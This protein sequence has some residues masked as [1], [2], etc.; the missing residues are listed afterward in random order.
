MQQNHILYATMHMQ[1]IICR[2][3]SAR[4]VVASWSIESMTK[5]H[6]M[7]I[8]SLKDHYKKIALKFTHILVIESS[9]CLWIWLVILNTHC[10]YIVHA[11]GI[12]FQT[13]KSLWHVSKQI[14]C[15]FFRI[16]G[17]AVTFFEITFILN[18]CVCCKYVSILFIFK[19]K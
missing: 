6:W 8:S 2:Q 18:K 13:M 1:T 15:P 16:C 11:Q 7:I 17:F 19:I 14:V 12:S 9:Q 5:V 10:T 4:H 3:L